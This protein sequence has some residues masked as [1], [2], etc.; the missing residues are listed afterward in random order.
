MTR[1]GG[2]DRGVASD[3]NSEPAPF[4]APPTAATDRCPLCGGD[5]DSGETRHLVGF[6]DLAE[7]SGTLGSTT[8]CSACWW[9]VFIATTPPF[10]RA[11]SRRLA[12][13]VGGRR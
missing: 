10:D 6:E 7:S 11:A 13:R 2:A 9:A 8:L 3:V 4:V 5:H 12:E 1:E